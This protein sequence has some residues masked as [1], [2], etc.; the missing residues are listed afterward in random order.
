M[1]FVPLFVALWKGCTTRARFI[2]FTVVGAVG[3][4]VA[5][6][7]R[8]TYSFDEVERAAGFVDW[9]GLS[10]VAPVAALVFGT[11]SLGDPIED[12]TYVYLWL[13]PIGRWQ[14]TMAAFAA[15]ASV[16]VP[17]SVVPTVIGAA[18]LSS[19]AAVIIGA[20]VATTL[21]AVAYSA[22]FVLIGQVTQ[23]ALVWGAV[24]LLIF[25][26]FIARGGSGLGFFS[27]HSHTVS[28]LAKT[29]DREINLDYFS[30]P[31]AVVMSLLIPALILAWSVQRQNRMDV[32]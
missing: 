2:S 26:Q 3:I 13:R 19:D 11:A 12:G 20:V 6:L 31:V 27:V 14:I 9:F 16:V 24:Y 29:V 23:R 25:E 8:G 30:R 32:A 7:L 10:L 22:V 1:T 18:L 4:A 21:A 28:I 17:F 15:T 5:A